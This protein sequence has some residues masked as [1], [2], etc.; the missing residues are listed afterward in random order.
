MPGARYFVTFCTAERRPWLAAGWTIRAGHDG[1]CE[2]KRSGDAEI[3]AAT[4]MPDH[5]H[6]LLV[7]GGRLSIAQ[8]VAKW[9]MRMRQA[10]G[11]PAGGSLWQ[12]NYF[13]HRLRADESSERYAW[14]IFMNPYA[15]GLRDADEKWPGWWMPEEWPRWEF[16]ERARPGP[17]PQAEWLGDVAVRSARLS[18]G[19]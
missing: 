1:F 2:L 4:I 13:E 16:L 17:L 9:K 12:A 7:L 14:Y 5:V 18:T 3:L 15:A 10:G 8:V 11:A 6:L 19:E